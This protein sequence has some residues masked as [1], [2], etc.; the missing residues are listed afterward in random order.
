MVI[1][2]NVMEQNG[3]RSVTVQGVEPEN[4]GVFHGWCR[5]PFFNDTGGYV[6]KTYA[7]IELANGKVKM[8]EPTM[9][10]FKEPY[11]VQDKQEALSAPL[12]KGG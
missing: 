10:R 4:Q 5:E 6:T 1:E 12:T 7:L 3:L 2:N 11:H 8:V 9:V